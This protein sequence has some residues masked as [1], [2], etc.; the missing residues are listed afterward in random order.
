MI[1]FD[2]NEKFCVP[3]VYVIRDIPKMINADE[4]EPVK[5]YLI[6]TSAE[7]DFVLKQANI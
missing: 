5:K 2:I 6:P 4:K 7:K 3:K 1:W